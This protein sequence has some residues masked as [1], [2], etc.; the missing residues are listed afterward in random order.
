MSLGAGLIG[1]GGFPWESFGEEVV[2]ISIL[3][4]NDVHSRI[5]PFPDNAGRLAN[6]GGAARRAAYIKAVRNKEPNVLLLDAG[7]I[8]QGTP[9]FNEFK[10]RLEFELMSR[11]K[12]DAATLGNHD[13]DLGLEGLMKQWGNAD[14]PFICSNYD[15]KDTPLNGKTLPYKV[16]ELQEIKIG[17][18]GLGIEL[19]GLVSNRLYGETQYLD[20]VKQANK[21]SKRLKK[22]LDCDFVIALSHLGMAYEGSDKIS[23]VRLVPQ[24]KYIDLVLGGHTHT[25]LNRP[26]VVSNKKGY[27][28]AINQVGYGGA[29]IG[30]IDLYFDIETRKRTTSCQNCWL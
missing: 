2:K 15:F 27:G 24:T 8:W 30:R 16:F 5:E 3:H 20:P 18:I 26:K 29:M 23:D 1:L 13:F 6:K 7:D 10:G 9:Y 25:F 11:M 19:E 12:Y 14:F 21:W 22:E 28:V 17:V 4:T